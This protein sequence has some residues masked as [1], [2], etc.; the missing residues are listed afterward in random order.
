MNKQKNENLKELFSCFMDEQAANEAAEDIVK[1]DELFDA[2]L[3]PQPSDGTIAKVKSRVTVELKRRHTTSIR[4][5]VFTTVG[6][7]AVLAVGAFLSL[8]FSERTQENRTTTQYAAAIPDRVWEG[9]DITSDDADIAV[10]SAEV[11]TLKN[12]IYGAQVD[13]SPVFNNTAVSDL[14]MEFAEISGDLWKG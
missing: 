13:D 5:K 14:E 10:L 11:E 3:A 1:A 7:A 2:Y 4:W 8:R 12:T 6:I 9:S